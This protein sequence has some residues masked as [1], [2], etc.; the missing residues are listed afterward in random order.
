MRQRMQDCYA[1]AWLSGVVAAFVG[2]VARSYS[3]VEPF[4]ALE[5]GRRLRDK[6]QGQGCILGVYCLASFEP[7]CRAWLHGGGTC[8]RLVLFATLLRKL[9]SVRR[10]QQ[11]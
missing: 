8:T 2:R 5:A 1:V 11:N 6:Q 7:D 9:V 4:R 3:G 10:A